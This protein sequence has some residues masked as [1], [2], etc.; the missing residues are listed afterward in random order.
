LRANCSG[1]VGGFL[2]MELNRERQREL[3]KEF[4]RAYRVAWGGSPLAKLGL[5][6][7]PIE[8]VNT[9]EER[10]RWARD[11]RKADARFCA[12]VRRHG[13]LPPAMAPSIVISLVS[14]GG[15]LLLGIEGARMIQKEFPRADFYGVTIWPEQEAQQ[16]ELIKAL[17]LHA[18]QP[19]L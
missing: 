10:T 4:P 18:E 2:I 7:M 11:L 12:Q 6:N 8:T 3:S 19:V 1:Q 15:H 17:R 14:T 5:G 13:P 9:P 16:R